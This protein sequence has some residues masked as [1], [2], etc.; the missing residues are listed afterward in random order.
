MGNVYFFSGYPGYLAT[1]L[2]K[3]IFQAE[4]PVQHIYALV[5]PSMMQD[6]EKSLKNLLNDTGID[7]GKITLVE[8]DITQE[9][10]GLEHD[11]I[12]LLQDSVTHVFHLAAIY[13]LAVPFEPAQKVN[14]FG[15]KNM[16][17]F[18]LSLTNLERYIYFSTAYVAGK[19]QG[20]IYEDE[21]E[22][23]KG[24]NNH[25]EKT[26]YEAEKLLEEL[27]SDIPITI[28]RPGIVVGHSETGETLKFDGPYFVLNFIRHLRFMPILP[29]FGNLDAKVNLVPL[30]YI[31]EATVFFA[32]DT[33]KESQTYHLT[34]PSPYTARELYSMFMQEYLGRKPRGRVP[35]KSAEMLLSIPFFRKWLQTEKQVL[36]Y[37]TDQCEYDCRNAQKGLENSTISCPD[38]KSIIPNL[39]KYYREHEKNEEKHVKIS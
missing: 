23:D 24:F 28:I 18:V 19:R 21:L 39:V 38:F 26:K 36:D 15:T 6:A 20:V 7:E 11:S 22:H 4:Y 17:D 2:I 25:Y 14:V 16:N 27:E 1:Y 10:L 37:F 35:L 33:S 3:R 32:H 9:N 31:I 29:Y 34:D 8:G 5:L 12:R 13:D 30:D